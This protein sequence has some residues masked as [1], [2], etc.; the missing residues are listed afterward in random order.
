LKIRNAFL[1]S[2]L[3][4]LFYLNNVQFYVKKQSNSAITPLKNIYRITQRTAIFQMADAGNFLWIFM[5]S[6]PL[7]NRG[8]SKIHTVNKI[9][10]EKMNQGFHEGLSLEIYYREISFT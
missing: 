7:V 9:R 4:S 3:F 5:V 6:N 10:E 2:L 8:L 1:L